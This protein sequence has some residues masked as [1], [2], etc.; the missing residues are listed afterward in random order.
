[1]RR[2]RIFLAVGALV[3]LV[4]WLAVSVLL[5]ESELPEPPPTA[6]QAG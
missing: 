2:H 1:M 3:L 6:E 5:T 4:G